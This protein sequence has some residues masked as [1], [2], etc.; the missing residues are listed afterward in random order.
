VERPVALIRLVAAVVLVVAIDPAGP[1]S[2]AAAGM[3]VWLHGTVTDLAGAPLQDVEILVAPVGREDEELT[4][5]TDRRGRY[6]LLLRRGDL[7]YLMT[8]GLAGH[9]TLLKT[10][11]PIV[12]TDPDEREGYSQVS[13]RRD[14][15][16][17]F[18]LP[19]E[20][21]VVERA[22]RDGGRGKVPEVEMRYAARVLHN[23][24]VEAAEAGAWALAEE[25]FRDTVRLDPALLGARSALVKV[26][27]ER[28]ALAGVAAA[29]EEAWQAGA[30][31][32]QVLLLHC[33]ALE[34]LGRESDLAEP[35]ARL[36]TV[37]RAAA[38]G[39]LHRRAA[40]AMLAGSDSE[41]ATILGDLLEVDPRNLEGLFLAGEVALRQGRVEEARR[42]LST[43]IAVAPSSPRATTARA[44]LA[45]L[46]AAATPPH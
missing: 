32:P 42:H 7:R 4:A 23:R 33:V 31:D 14:F 1:I 6:R 16:A 30:R 3:E 10:V 22:R 24:G 43:L 25:L 19:N 34:R 37:D 40:A 21:E 8:V 35:V 9:Q 38:T 13:S 45:E 41:A 18:A 20:E 11:Q 46:E 17:D 39:F 26:L 29:A 27:Y 28:G 36:A 2:A 5:T 15:V 44:L 12:V